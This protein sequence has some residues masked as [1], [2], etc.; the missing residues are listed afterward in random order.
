[1]LALGS[2][3][4][5]LNSLESDHHQ[6]DSSNGCMY[7]AVVVKQG[8]NAWDESI[9]GEAALI[10]RFSK[11]LTHVA[12]LVDGCQCEQQRPHLTQPSPS[13][14]QPSPPSAW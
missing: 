3:E 13:P 4:D 1:M 8:D 14:P 2:G 12:R 7:H 11:C 6:L 5:N 10:I 9:L